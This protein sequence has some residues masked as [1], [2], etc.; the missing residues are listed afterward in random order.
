MLTSQAWRRLAQ[1]T[2]ALGL[3]GTL[4]V[5]TGSVFVVST[6]TAASAAAPKQFSYTCQGGP[7][8]FA[9]TPINVSLS[10]PDSV[11][12]GGTF[13]L[14]VGIPGL[15]QTTPAAQATYV[16]ATVTLT[17]TGGSVT[18]A[19]AKQGA[20][21][22]ANTA[23]IPAGDVKYKVSVAAA[24]TSK[25]S[26]KPGEIKLGLL[27]NTASVATCTPTSTEVLDIPIGT[28]G[29]TGTEVVAYKCDLVD[30]T[31]NDPEFPADVN[32]KFTPT[33]PTNAKTNEDAS[34]TWTSA[35]DSTSPDQLKAPTGFPTTGGKYFLTLKASGAGVPATAT[36]EGALTGIVAGQAITTLPSLTFKIKPTSTG[37]VTITPG[38]F[39]LGT[40]AT[41]TTGSAVKCVAP[42]TGLKTYTFTVTAGTGSSNSP[43]PSPSP[44]PTTTSPKPTKTS[45][46]TV[47]VT[48]PNKS[49]TPKAGAD[50][51][52]G[53]DAGP[54]GRMF[55]LTGT[56]LVAA[57]AAGGLVLRR[58]TATRG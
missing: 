39:V 25:V 37:T 21:V 14:S 1:K 13:D 18:D 38:D 56:L 53:G 11:T 20:A 34:V 44:T 9:A 8:T 47:T 57:A 10:G 16:Q 48:P 31:V 33:M 41:Q 32:V 51:G 40:S 4:A 22:A 12:A 46:A 26:I 24:T 7:F 29:G 27:S 35:I 2:S 42:T 15:T 58:R 45:T 55:I 49:K 28:G 52:A 30:T 43:S 19:G 23:T 54:D 17:P 6:P 3:M 36:A 5:F 50:T